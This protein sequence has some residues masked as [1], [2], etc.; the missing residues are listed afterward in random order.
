VTQFTPANP[1]QLFGGMSDFTLFNLEGAR[2]C[3][4]GPRKIEDFV[5][6]GGAV[7]RVSLRTQSGGEGCGT[8][9][10]EGV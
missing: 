2:W 4:R 7:E 9:A 10:D 8:R 5:G 1:G 6:R 3:I